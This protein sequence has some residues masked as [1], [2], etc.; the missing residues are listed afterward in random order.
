MKKSNGN[1][2]LMAFTNG[3]KFHYGVECE[4][5]RV[6]VFLQVAENVRQTVNLI[7]GIDATRKVVKN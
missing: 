5:G 2:T 1:N 7:L 6:H 4:R 3:S